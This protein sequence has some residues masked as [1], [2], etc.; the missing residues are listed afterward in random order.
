MVFMKTVEEI[1]RKRLRLLEAECGSVIALS[2]KLV[3][4]SSQISQWLNASPDAKTGKPRSINNPSARRIEK[5][6]NKPE[7]W[8]DQPIPEETR[9]NA[10]A[11]P[12]LRAMVPLISFI[13]AGKWEEAADPYPPGEA[14][15]WFP[16]IKKNGERVF[17]LRVD[18]DSMTSAIGK[19]YPHG[20]VIFVDPEQRTPTNGARIVAKLEGSN[21]VVFKVFMQDAGRTWLRAL[22]RDYD[23]IREPFKVIGTVVGKWEDE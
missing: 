8:M 10:F 2:T 3:R 14:E 12:E 17:A 9:S 22:N 16:Y 20:C 15:K 7:G 5:V 11:G 1:R 13:Q 6:F 18:G 21:Q 4:S 19:S 23:P